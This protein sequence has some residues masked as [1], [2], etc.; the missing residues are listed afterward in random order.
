MEAEWEDRQEHSRLHRG[1]AEPSKHQAPGRLWRGWSGHE[2]IRR[3]PTRGSEYAAHEAAAHARDVWPA[4]PA[5]PTT[6]ARGRTRPKRLSLSGRQC[7]GWWPLWRRRWRPW[8]AWFVISSTWRATD[9]PPPGRWYDAPREYGF[10]P[11]SGGKTFTWEGPDA[12]DRDRPKVDGYVIPKD[13]GGPVCAE[14]AEVYWLF[15]ALAHA[16]FQV[17]ARDGQQRR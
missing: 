17:S 1:Q 14:T 15:V 2:P 6:T 12:A 11:A 13:G 9:A 3:K 5:P 4:A 7:D 8:F 10:T 16:G